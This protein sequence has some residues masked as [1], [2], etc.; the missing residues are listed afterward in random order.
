MAQSEYVLGKI[1]ERRLLIAGY[2]NSNCKKHVPE[3]VVELVLKWYGNDI[4][5]WDTNRINSGK[6]FFD[7]KMNCI[8]RLS[9]GWGCATAV[10]AGLISKD[11]KY[12]IWRLKCMTV[13]TK[14]V[15]SADSP[16]FAFVVGL[17]PSNY[18]VKNSINELYYVGYGL[19]LSNNELKS[20]ELCAS[21]QHLDIQLQT[22]DVINILYQD[23]GAN[24]ELFY[25]KN[26][27][28]WMKGFTKIPIENNEKYRFAVSLR[29]GR[30]IQMIQ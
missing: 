14:K 21:G 2:A 24:G 26:D 6:I 27:G 19:D 7:E 28:K 1:E 4:D 16:S 25:S 10:G 17:I 20:R 18:Y 5:Y 29:D 30:K 23:N 11:T 9:V 13:K 22:N 8:Q 12:K 3:N 15:H